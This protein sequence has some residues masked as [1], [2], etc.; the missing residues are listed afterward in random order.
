[1]RLPPPAWT[2]LESLDGDGTEGAITNTSAVGRWRFYRLKT[3]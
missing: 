2:A 3:D 1:V